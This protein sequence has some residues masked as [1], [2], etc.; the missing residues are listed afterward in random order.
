MC[1]SFVLYRQKATEGVTEMIKITCKDDLDLIADVCIKK[2]IENQLNY[3]LNT[4]KDEC[5]EGSI[6]SIG[7]IFYVEMSSDFESYT[8]FG[9]SSPIT[10][11]R[12]EYI[13]LLEDGYCKGLIVIDNERAIELIGKKNAFTHLLKGE[14]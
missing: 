12:F 3:L 10:E 14:F 8:Q 13:E 1:N 6:E 11:E 2:H 7:A 4:Y 5:S 9:L